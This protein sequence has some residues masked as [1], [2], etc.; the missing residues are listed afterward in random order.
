MPTQAVLKKGAH[1]HKGRIPRGNIATHTLWIIRVKQ[2]SP[3]KMVS[4]G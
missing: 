2:A 4:P 3:R 1:K